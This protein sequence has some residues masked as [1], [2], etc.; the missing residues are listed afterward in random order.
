MRSYCGRG[1]SLSMH[2]QA[3]T[4]I[5]THTLSRFFCQVE[6]IFAPNPVAG[7]LPWQFSAVYIENK[8]P[9]SVTELSSILSL[10]CFSLSQWLVFQSHC[11]WQQEG[12]GDGSG[13]RVESSISLATWT[14]DLP[15]R[16]M[17]NKKQTCYL[18]LKS[19]PVN[20]LKLKRPC[21]KAQNCWTVSVQFVHITQSYSGELAVIT[22]PGIN[23]DGLLYGP[24]SWA[25][26]GFFLAAVTTGLLNRGKEIWINAVVY[27]SEMYT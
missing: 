4:P 21:V 3:H 6:F 2:A 8:N 13:W 17:I 24:S 27:F 11:L 9:E 19:L 18:T 16:H 15:A 1:Q 20:E 26:R 12:G 23:E 14:S 22:L 5:H 7:K 25:L 10:L